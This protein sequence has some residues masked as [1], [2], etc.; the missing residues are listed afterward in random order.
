MTSMAELPN[1]MSALSLNSV[2][3]LKPSRDLSA[4]LDV[5]SRRR[6]ISSVGRTPRPIFSAQWLRL[7][8][9]ARLGS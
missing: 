8:R 2:W 1:V 7:E 6:M 3:I 4:L 9:P 5:R